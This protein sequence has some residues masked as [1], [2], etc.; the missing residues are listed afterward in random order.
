MSSNL[1]TVTIKD[2]KSQIFNGE[3]LSITSTNK[4][5]KF[6]VLP[7]HSNFISLIK[8]FVIVREQNKKEITIPLQSGVLRV[9][10]DKVN[11]LIGV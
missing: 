1:L 9:G 11:I 6:D 4:K 5:G 7:L 10:G 8:D 2:P 3:V